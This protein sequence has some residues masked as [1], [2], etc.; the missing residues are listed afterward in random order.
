MAVFGQMFVGAAS[1]VKHPKHFVL[2]RTPK[3]PRQQAV[4]V[5]I[6]VLKAH[7]TRTA[8][9][10]AKRDFH[11]AQNSR[12][13]TTRD[14]R[15]PR[16]NPGFKP[17]TFSSD[18]LSVEKVSI[19]AAG[20]VAFH[21]FR[22]HQS[23]LQSKYMVQHQPKNPRKQL[24]KTKYPTRNLRVASAGDVDQIRALE[25]DFKV[26]FKLG[27]WFLL[28]PV[29]V[30]VTER[31]PVF[32][33][34]QGHIGLR[35]T[36]DVQSLAG[37]DDVVAIDPG[38][39]KPFTCYSPQGRVDVLG[40]NVLKVA[41]KSLWRIRRRRA[42][43]KAAQQGFLEFR[44]KHLRQKTHYMASEPTRA[45]REVYIRGWRQAKRREAQVVHRVHQRYR[46]AEQ[47]QRNIVKNFHYNVSH[48]LLRRYK[49]IILPSTSS[50]YWR[51]G[52]RLTRSTKRLIQ[53]LALGSFAAR[54]VQTASFYP[55]RQILRGSEAY[56][57]K[58]CG[59]CGTLADKLGGSEVFRCRKCGA[60]GDRDVHAARNIALRFLQ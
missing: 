48:Y 39:R 60:Q 37:A 2:L 22:N 32:K 18:S 25:R 50:H 42:Q 9:W 52:K 4:K 19:S 56:T 33:A 43:L 46:R 14:R 34:P 57:S 47:K 23:I 11:L 38:V 7:H 10:K 13:K 41:S 21:L 58:Q 35:W 40:V 44:E 59:R 26:H 36:E 15:A 29:A 17:N 30:S 55:G 12:V 51:K 28:L 27:R 3:V 53:F 24:W 49:V 6:S 31:L 45:A 5:V 8:K 1:L 54:L 16:F 20:E